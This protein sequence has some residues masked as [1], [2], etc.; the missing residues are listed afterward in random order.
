[1]QR[2]TMPAIVS[3]RFRRQ[4]TDSKVQ[5]VATGG[6]NPP[7]THGPG[8][9]IR[10]SPWLLPSWA[11]PPT[12]GRIRH[13]G[14][15]PDRDPAAGLS[16]CALRTAPCSQ[17]IRDRPRG[18]SGTPGRHQRG[19]RWW[20]VVSPEAGSRRTTTLVL[21]PC[22]RSGSKTILQAAHPARLGTL[23][24]RVFPLIH[25]MKRYTKPLKSH[26]ERV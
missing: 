25:Q 8:Q 24:N 4:A 11:R 21:R 12:R 2:S 1:L 19:T 3:V 18:P 5:P 17:H 26:T 15:C 22:S 10:S 14:Q 23:E 7:G 6:D 20:R 13:R 16:G 9:P